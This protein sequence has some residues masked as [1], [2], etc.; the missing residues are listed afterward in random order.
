MDDQIQTIMMTIEKACRAVCETEIEYLRMEEELLFL[1]LK[2]KN[3][4]QHVKNKIA[5][6]ITEINKKQLQI[7]GH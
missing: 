2:N 6:E 1:A 4:P 3:I 7:M 5:M